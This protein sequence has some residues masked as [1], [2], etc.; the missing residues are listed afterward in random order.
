MCRSKF[1]LSISNSF[2]PPENI[3]TKAQQILKTEILQVFSRDG[4]LN[5][6]VQNYS[7]RVFISKV[8]LHGNSYMGFLYG[9]LLTFR[10]PKALANVLGGIDKH[11]S[12]SEM[13]H[14]GN[15]IMSTL[16]Y[17]FRLLATVRLVLNK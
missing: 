11:C 6:S 8:F 13:K 12:D 2:L 9:Y 15:A 4:I 16:L 1:Q 17:L 3:I 7:S 5:F 14:A 10:L